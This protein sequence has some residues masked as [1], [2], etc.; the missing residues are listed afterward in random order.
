MSPDVVVAGEDLPLLLESP[1]KKTSA[2]R[3]MDG[4]GRFPMCARPQF[5][6]QG[7]FLPISK[8]SSDVQAVG[9]E[10]AGWHIWHFETLQDVTTFINIPCLSM[11]INVWDDATISIILKD[12]SWGSLIG[13][14]ETCRW[15]ENTSMRPAKTTPWGGTGG[16]DKTSR[17]MDVDSI[18]DLIWIYIYI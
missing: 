16:N 11:F 7:T 17:H 8:F 12:P 5:L 15:W 10:G 2:R 3:R 4:A 18:Y 6:C 1:W 14:A 13:W 9:Q